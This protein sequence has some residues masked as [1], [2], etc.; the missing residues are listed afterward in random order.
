MMKLVH[1]GA[2]FEHQQLCHFVMMLDPAYQ[3]KGYG[4]EA[5]RW[6][7]RTGF[8]HANLHRIESSYYYDNLPAAKLYRKVSVPALDL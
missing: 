1:P 7:L 3:G 4:E 2:G 5:L 6:L 8:R